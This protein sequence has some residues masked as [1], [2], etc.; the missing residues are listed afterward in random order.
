MRESYIGTN[1][2]GEIT[3]YVGHDATRLVRA[4]L[5]RSG[6]RGY[7]LFKMIPTRGVTITRMLEMTTEFSGQKYKRGEY[8]RA[9]DDLTVWIAT[10]ESALPVI[11]NEERND[12]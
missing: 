4:K 2:K 7:I 10:M 8:Q 3:S 6:I 1:D 11:K 12:V 5:L 9:V